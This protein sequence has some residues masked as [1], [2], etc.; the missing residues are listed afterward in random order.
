MSYKVIKPLVIS[1]FI[2]DKESPQISETKVPLKVEASGEGILQYKFL[3]K[4]NKTGNWAIL[5]DYGTSNTYTWTT[6]TTGDKTLYVDVK[7]STGKVVRSQMSYKVIK[8]L[9]ISS[10]IADKESPQISGTKVTLK[11]EASGEGTLQYKFLIKDSLGNWAL[12]R[13]YGTSNSYVWTTKQ[14]GDK[15][16]YV[17]VKDENEQVVRDSIKYIVK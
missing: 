12:L 8:P 16:L 2:A 13:D 5:R 4:D 9:V 6:K 7:D 15:T 17:D 14:T 3:I 1:S 10:F 11:V